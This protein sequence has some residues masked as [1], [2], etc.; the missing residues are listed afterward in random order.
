MATNVTDRTCHNY[1][2][3]N[4]HCMVAFLSYTAIIRTALGTGSPRAHENGMRLHPAQ[5]IERSK[6]MSS[7]STPPKATTELY[8][9]N[10]CSQPLTTT[11]KFSSDR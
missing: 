1:G 4:Y 8:A 7:Y 11:L 6:W 10:Y 2:H 3:I 5:K 9:L